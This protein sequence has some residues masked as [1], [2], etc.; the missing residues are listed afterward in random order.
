MPPPETKSPSPTHTINNPSVNSFLEHAILNH[1]TNTPSNPKRRSSNQL[2]EEKEKPN[3]I[4]H[5]NTHIATDLTTQPNISRAMAFDSNRPK[6]LRPDN[7]QLG[8]IPC[9]GAYY[10]REAILTKDATHP[11]KV[12][13]EITYNEVCKKISDYVLD[14]KYELMDIWDK[15]LKDM[16]IKALTEKDD[17]NNNFFNKDSDSMTQLGNTAFEA[18]LIFCDANPSLNKE[19]NGHYDTGKKNLA[20]ELSSLIPEILNKSKEELTPFLTSSSRSHA[21][22]K[23]LNALIIRGANFDKKWLKIIHDTMPTAKSGTSTHTLAKDITTLQ[24]DTELHK[25][26]LIEIDNQIDK[27]STRL[28]DLKTSE[29]ENRYNQVENVIRLHNINYIDSNT[30][31]HF[32]TLNHTDKIKRIHQLV[33]DYVT[34]NTGFSTQVITPNP[35]GRQFEPLAIITFQNADGKYLFEKKFAVFRR[36]NPGTKLTTSRPVPQTTASDRDM[37]ELQDIREKIGMLYNS[38][39]GEAIRHNPNIEYK[40]LTRQEIGAIE[41]KL[42]QKRK[43]FSTYW[44][45]LCPSNNSTFMVYTPN[46]NPFSEYDFTNKIANPLTRRNAN[47][48]KQYEKRF[49]PKIHTKRN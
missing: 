13:H 44:E 3:K 35:S 26:E 17:L 40:P 14:N 30:T 7:K 42:K 39:V 49:P 4:S 16:M 19:S 20:T 37:P 5:S 6:M 22:N 48:D 41:V 46:K 11:E 21:L 32:R 43:P 47:N 27:I 29:L 15:Q 1:S 9:V 24:K 12:Q 36:T 10:T 34:P 8:N 25:S 2:S 31:H 23:D 18:F 33:N 28:G 38:S 45:F